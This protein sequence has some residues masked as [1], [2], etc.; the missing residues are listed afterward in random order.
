MNWLGTEEKEDY[1]YRN[2]FGEGKWIREPSNKYNQGFYQ[3]LQGYIMSLNQSRPFDQN[4]KG[5]V[6]ESAKY[7]EMFAL[8][9]LE[10]NMRI[11]G[12]QNQGEKPTLSL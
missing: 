6:M 9:R 1:F 3:G 4:Q 11:P 5:D 10:L 12:R 2:Q 7:F 8:T